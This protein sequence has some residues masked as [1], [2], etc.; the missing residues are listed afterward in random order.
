MS[1]LSESSVRV[2]VAILG[3]VGAIFLPWYVPAACIVLLSLRFPAVEAILLGAS[4]DLLWLPSDSFFQSMPLF[5]IGAL[6][7][8]WGFEPLRKQFLQ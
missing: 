8:V 2:A 7:L 6:I 1:S 5:T 4:M 3:F